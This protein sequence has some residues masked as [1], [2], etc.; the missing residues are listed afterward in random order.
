LKV[1]QFKNSLVLQRQSEGQWRR[2]R[3]MRLPGRSLIRSPLPSFAANANQQRSRSKLSPALSE[4]G[5]SSPQT[6]GEPSDASSDLLN[7]ENQLGSWE[8]DS[9]RSASDL[10]AEKAGELE[11]H[12]RQLAAEA[13]QQGTEWEPLTASM[14]DSGEGM[15]LVAGMG[16]DSTEQFASAQPVQQNGRS[17]GRGS[18]SAD[19]EARS[20]ASMWPLSLYPL[21]YRQDYSP[22]D[23]QRTGSAL[24]ADDPQRFDS[25]ALADETRSASQ[26]DNRSCRSPSSEQLNML[27]SELNGDTT[28][29]SSSLVDP[30]VSLSN[31]ALQSWQKESLPSSVSDDYPD[32]EQASL[33]SRPKLPALWRS[34]RSQL[35]DAAEK[36]R[37]AACMLSALCKTLSP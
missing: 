34:R 19:T 4:L 21:S 27:S 35:P 1:S 6:S 10:S 8:E 9:S 29:S 20:L 5:A 17:N 37:A 14:D 15:D 30:L 16:S 13:R 22:A 28:E 2:P 7:W 33:P 11:A 23:P 18:R 25:S 26:V 36:A 24:A 12:A 3:L 31:G 32:D